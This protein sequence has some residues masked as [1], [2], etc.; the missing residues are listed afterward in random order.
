[1]IWVFVDIMKILK[2]FLGFEP[3]TQGIEVLV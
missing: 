1:M 2:I 3:G